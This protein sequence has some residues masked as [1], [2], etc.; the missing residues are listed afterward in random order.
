M[1]WLVGRVHFCN[2]RYHVG[3]Y[4]RVMI[5]DLRSGKMMFLRGLDIRHAHQ[6]NLSVNH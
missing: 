2:V 3:C 1:L 4:I 5:V 6:R